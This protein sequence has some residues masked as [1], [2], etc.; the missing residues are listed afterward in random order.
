MPDWLYITKAR[1]L[2]SGLTHEGRLFGVPAWFD[3]ESDAAVA[4]ATPKIPAL[5][6]WCMLGDCLMELASY[7]L[8]ADAV[9]A[10]P[11]T[12]TGRIEA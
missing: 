9:L 5:H 6:A 12:I 7:V 1:A 11:I 2:E 8:P 3:G 4:I 10:S